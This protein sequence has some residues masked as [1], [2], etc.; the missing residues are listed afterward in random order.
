MKYVVAT[1]VNFNMNQFKNM[2]KEL[3]SKLELQSDICK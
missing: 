1:T 3:T 2:T